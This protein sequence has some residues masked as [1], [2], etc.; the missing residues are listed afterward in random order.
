MSLLSNPRHLV[1]VQP[2]KRVAGTVGQVELVPDGD[3]VTVRCNVH[4]LSSSELVSFGVRE[5]VDGAITATSWPFDENCRISYAG[6]EY[7]QDS[8]PV[9]YTMGRRTRHLAIGIRR[10][11]KEATS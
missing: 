10:R 1:T 3:P 2:Y 6:V 8:L 7:D 11:K 5:F 9:P 4:L